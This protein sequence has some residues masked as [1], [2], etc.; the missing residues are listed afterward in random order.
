[1]SP[2]ASLSSSVPAPSTTS[3]V[4]T[5][6]A[7]LTIPVSMSA[8]AYWRRTNGL[9]TP[10]WVKA[11]ATWIMHA[12]RRFDRKS[13]NVR[14]RKIG[15]FA[16][17]VRMCETSV[18]QSASTA[19]QFMS[20]SAVPKAS[21]SSNSVM[22]DG[23]LP[24]HHAFGGTH[25]F[26]QLRSVELQGDEAIRPIPGRLIAVDVLIE[27]VQ[28]VAARDQVLSGDPYPISLRL[29]LA[30]HQVVEIRVTAVA[31]AAAIHVPELVLLVQHAAMFVTP[32]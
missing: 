2:R 32:I 1:M 9:T 5:A 19:L 25:R 14:S 3:S 31:D 4:N 17:R 12:K 11:S 24:Q 18:G 21:S 13:F 6:T 28:H 29:R 10:A 26:N 20:C 27:P 8:C 15:G 23:P 22:T 30:K 7:A 16:P